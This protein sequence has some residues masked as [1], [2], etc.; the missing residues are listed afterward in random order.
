[1]KRQPELVRDLTV[2]PARDDPAHD[3][4]FAECQINHG[5]HRALVTFM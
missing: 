2:R 4:A 5:G 3:V 1:L